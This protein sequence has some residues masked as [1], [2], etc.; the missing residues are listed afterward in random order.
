MV[1]VPLIHLS[2]F[3]TRDLPFNQAT[4]LYLFSSKHA[5]KIRT[6]CMGNVIFYIEVNARYS[7]LHFKHYKNQSIPVWP[8]WAI[9][10]ILGSFLKPLATINLTKSPTFLGNFCKGVKIYHFSFEIIFGE[11]LQTFGYF[12]L[13]T[14]LPTY[15]WQLNRPIKRK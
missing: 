8:D 5:F 14:L 13:V 3:K 2:D 10:W 12:Y 4:W 6:G 7:Y 15:L 1:S 9:Y 11:L